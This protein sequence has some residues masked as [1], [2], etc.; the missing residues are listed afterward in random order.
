[1]SNEKLLP[2]PFCNTHAEVV[3]ASH[4]RCANI[5]NCDC[6]TRLGNKAWNRRAALAAQNDELADARHQQ[7]L[8]TVFAEKQKA[9]YEEQIARLREE[10]AKALQESEMQRSIDIANAQAASFNAGMTRA[11]EIC[12]EM[13]D[14][15][16]PDKKPFGHDFAKAI[17][18]A[19][20]D[21]KP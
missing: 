18:K 15:S 11:A 17:L 1:M 8:A 10:V 2:C 5:Y 16:Y 7:H 12:D 3:H 9:E 21:S 4:I 13:D 20:D 14:A 19:R 6:H